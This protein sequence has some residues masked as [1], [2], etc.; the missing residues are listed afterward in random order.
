MPEPKLYIHTDGTIRVNGLK[1]EDT[2]SVINSATITVS[3]FRETPLYIEQSW[4]NID[5]G[6]TREIQAGDII[7]GGT[8]GATAYIQSIELLAGAWPSNTAEAKLFLLNQ[9]GTF[10]NDEVLNISGVQNA[11]VDGG[12]STG[13]VS[14][15]AGADTK[16]TIPN[17]G[18]TTV[19]FIYIEG[20][21]NYEKQKDVKTLDDW[22]N[23]TIDDAYVAE[24]FTGLEK[25][26]VGL[27]NAKDIAVTTT[28]AG[29]NYKGTLPDS[30]KKLIKDSFYHVRWLIVYGTSNINLLKRWEA[31]YYEG[32]VS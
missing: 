2:E 3:I 17:H 15:A 13:A 7:T 32:E 19:D 27:R 6:G 16:I 23:I 11:L 10:Q 5:A 8:S 12:D 1:D 29:G 21:Y 24:K 30:V 31:E 14:V 26:F 18:L 4:L 22:Q 28:G 20:S 25:V 9:I